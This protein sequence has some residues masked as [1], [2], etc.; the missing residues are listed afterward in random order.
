MT[1][2]FLGIV[3]GII[4]GEFA[5]PLLATISEWFN[6][7]VAYRINIMNLKLEQYGEEPSKIGFSPHN[8]DS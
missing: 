2:L 1:Y 5:F 8:Q 3:I 7:Y 4:L 6:N